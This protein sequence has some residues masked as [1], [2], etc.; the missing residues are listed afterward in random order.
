[1]LGAVI[2]VV[3]FLVAPVALFLGG[4]AWSAAFGT[5]LVETTDP[6][7]PEA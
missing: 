7:S 4:A 6:Q 3:A 2:I 1:M 5:V